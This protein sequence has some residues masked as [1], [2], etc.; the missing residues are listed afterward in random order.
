MLLVGKMVIDERTME[1]KKKRFDCGGVRGDFIGYAGG[2][3]EWS[4]VTSR[5]APVTQKVV[6]LLPDHSRPTASSAID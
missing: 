6:P 4:P 5:C 3:D 1:R 2:G